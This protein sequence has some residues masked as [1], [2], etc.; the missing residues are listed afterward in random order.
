V[1]EVGAA[2]VRHKW[3]RGPNAIIMM[4]IRMCSLFVFALNHCQWPN[5]LRNCLN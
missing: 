1:G 4:M 2:L 3:T 5:F